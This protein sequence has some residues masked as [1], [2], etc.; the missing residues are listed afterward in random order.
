MMSYYAESV[1]SVWTGKYS[2]YTRS[3]LPHRLFQGGPKK[4]GH[5]L[6][7]DSAHSGSV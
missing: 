2:I 1:V 6:S 7:R 5:V 3:E 4:P